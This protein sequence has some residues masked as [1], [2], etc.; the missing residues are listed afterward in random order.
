MRSFILIPCMEMC[1]LIVLS[2]P[3]FANLHDTVAL[4]FL[5]T[6]VLDTGKHRPGWEFSIC[7]RYRSLILIAKIKDL[8]QDCVKSSRPYLDNDIQHSS[9]KY[10]LIRL[11]I[12]LISNMVFLFHA[13]VQTANVLFRQL[14][15][16]LI[17]HLAKV[18]SHLNKLYAH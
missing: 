2:L 9:V 18:F 1:Q 7:Q 12:W 11:I 13:I 15:L 10:H 4:R 14:L 8:N 3:Y 16:L 17:H 5:R 6:F